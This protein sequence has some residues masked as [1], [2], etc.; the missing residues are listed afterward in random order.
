MAL[1]VCKECNKQISDTAKECIGC[2]AKVKSFKQASIGQYAFLLIFGIIVYSCVAKDPVVS[3][4]NSVETKSNLETKKTARPTNLSGTTYE[5]LCLDAGW[6]IRGGGTAN[7]NISEY[8]IDAGYIDEIDAENIKNKTLRIGGSR[9]MLI[10]S[11]GNADKVNTTTNQY[12][13][14][15]Q[16]IYG[17]SYVYT[18][19]DVITTVQQN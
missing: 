7:S 14:S 1:I 15:R 19:D 4:T 2:G 6:R 5:E 18:D 12:G 9:C 8:M 3:E 11:W 10:G 17:N 16:H 13:T